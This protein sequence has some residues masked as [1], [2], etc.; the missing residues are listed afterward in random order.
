[1]VYSTIRCMRKPGTMQNKCEWSCTIIV[2]K[3]VC[4]H[5]YPASRLTEHILVS[6]LVPDAFDLSQM[7]FIDCASAHTASQTPFHAYQRYS[8]PNYI[9]P[10]ESRMLDHSLSW[11]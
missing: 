8:H 6:F 10:D 9:L 2:R 7:Q 5:S 4:H 1:M 3:N 11:V